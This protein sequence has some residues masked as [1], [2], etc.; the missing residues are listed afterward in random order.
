MRQRVLAVRC[1]HHLQLALVRHQPS[2]AAAE[3]GDAGLGEVFL[4]LV[5][6]A[7]VGDDLR[8]QFARNGT[9][10][11]GLHPAPEVI[12]VPGLPGIVEDDLLGRVAEA[13]GDDVLQAL[14]GVRGSFDQLVQRG[15]IGV[16]VLAVMVLQRFGG[17]EGLKGVLRVGQRGQFEGHDGSLSFLLK[18]SRKRAETLIWCSSSP[19]S[20]CDAQPAV[21]FAC[22][23]HHAPITVET[24]HA[25]R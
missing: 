24:P 12:V 5:D 11:I 10:A 17:H 13:G 9:A 20:R 7:E 19:L 22:D 2:P 23:D 1:L 21:D 18:R 16:V 4:H 6:A 25:G 8:L 15:D 3:L 14:A